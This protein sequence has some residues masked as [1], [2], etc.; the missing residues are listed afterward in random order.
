LDQI[1]SES[2]HIRGRNDLLFID[3]D[4][5]KVLEFLD[6]ANV[7]PRKYQDD[8]F[9]LL[10]TGTGRWLLDSE[11]FK[12]WFGT[13]R[14]KLWLEG[15]AGAGKTILMSLIVNHGQDHLGEDD[16][17]AYYYCDYK[18]SD[19]HNTVNILG[20]IAKQLA[21]RDDSAFEKAKDL[22][23]HHHPEGQLNSASTAEE[24]LNLTLDLSKGFANT[25]II[26]DGLDGCV[27][28]QSEVVEYLQMLGSQDASPDVNIKI[29]LASRNEYV[30]REK[31]QDKYEHVSIAARSEDLRLYVAAEIQTRMDQ[32]KPRI[33][34]TSLKQHIMDRLVEKADGM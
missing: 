28:S 14:S 6:P 32:G 23:A 7:N 30:I 31:L 19:T 33:G 10:Q 2:K 22:Y 29:L 13:P 4:R 17:V 18:N 16:A 1:K 26:V 5:Q 25:L 3:W 21:I 11:E 27:S 9:T 8:A 12:H 15:I 24:L 20:S 34:Q